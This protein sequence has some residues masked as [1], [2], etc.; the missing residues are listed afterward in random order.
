MKHVTLCLPVN[1]DQLLLGMK[2][3]G[4][5]AGNYN[6][7]GGKKEETDPSIEDA[8]LRELTEEVGLCATHDA[9][10]KVGELTFLF[11]SV[12]EDKNWNQVVHVYLIKTWTGT[13]RETNE[14]RPVWVSL[15]QIPYDK[16]WEADRYWLPLVLQ[17]KYVT[18]KFVYSEDKKLVEKGVIVT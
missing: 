5:G 16:M 3:T 9:L 4:F 1:H 8:A 7:F 11:P 15:A 2:K 6:G 10:Q 13:P 17:G 14:M 12:P 18:A